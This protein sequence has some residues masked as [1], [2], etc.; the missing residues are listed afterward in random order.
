MS[1]PTL[2]GTEFQPNTT[3]LLEQD[4]PS[5]TALPNGNF[6]VVWEDRSA[7]VGDTSGD[8]VRGQLYHSNGSRIGGEFLVNQ[9]TTGNQDDAVVTAL[10]D[11]RFVVAWRNEVG[12]GNTDVYARIYNANGTPASAEFLVNTVTANAQSEPAIAAA[13]DGGFLITWTNDFSATDQDIRGRAFNAAGAP[14]GIDFPIDV[15]AGIDETD[16]AV[17]AL[18][19]NNYVVVWKDEGAPME[20]DGSGSHIR[21]KIVSD[22]GATVVPSFIINSTATGDQ[23]EPSIALLGNGG[24]V[25]TWTSGTGDS[26]EIRAR[27][28][29]SAGVP[30]GA[31]F[32]VDASSS[33]Q[34]ASVSALGAGPFDEGGFMVTWQESSDIH[35]KIFHGDGTAGESFV[36]NATLSGMQGQPRL[37]TLADGRIVATWTDLDGNSA[38]VRGQIF[39]P[40][41][42][43]AFVDG[44]DLDDHLIGTPVRDVMKGGGG[45]DVLVGLD[46]DDVFIGDAGTDDL[47]GGNGI[48]TVLYNDSNAAVSV[49]L[50]TGLGFG[51]DAQ[52]DVLSS[53]ENL[54]GSDHADS[55]HGDASNNVIKG[56]GGA[57]V[58]TGGGGIDT[59]SY[60][61]SDV[62]V[63]VS[64]ATG[65]GLGGEAQGDTLAGFRN[66]TGSN[67]GDTLIGD[68]LANVLDG[69][70]GNDTLIGGVGADTLNG[71]SGNDTLDYTA[72]DAAVLINLGNGMAGGGHATGDTFTDI[73][74]VIGTAFN[75]TLFGN[76]EANVLEGGVGADTLDGASGVDTL[77]YATSNAA[78]LINLGNGQTL[79]G[80]AQGDS[81]ASIENLI[82]SAHDDGLFG[83]GLVNVLTGG[84]GND[85]LYGGLNNDT[86]EG[87]L[88]ADTCEGGAGI[89]TLS[90]AGSN[91]AVLINVGNGMALGG[92][93]QGDSYTSIENVIGSSH[94]DGLF[95]N[96][97]ANVLT[98][99]AG[100]DYLYGGLNADIFVF[101]P[102]FGKDTIGDFKKSEGDRIQ[103]DN[104]MFQNF[105]AVQS[106]MQQV[107]A[108]TVI[109][110]DAQNAITLE[111][112]TAASL[113]ASDFLFV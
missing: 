25:V 16:A 73:Q 81:F 71:G 2:F 38:G 79:G 108:H 82:G 64:L 98:G 83:D 100:N 93:A 63:T 59:A 44:S 4:T 106:K 103:L 57:D 10:S 42:D 68:A 85:Y 97:L 76:G 17:V 26:R 7:S 51:G 70:G 9:T 107:G 5:I 13:P 30:Q 109:T 15:T 72:S 22:T 84:A 77:S 99:G 88:G 60:E 34:T 62:G 48:D 40:R 29:D 14:V 66:L 53:I 75:D 95:G 46:G 47:R 110:L 3:D 94:N 32:V 56:G 37:A 52:G 45:N 89:D 1:I 20:T 31:D 105:A 90:Y 87:G 33:A 35:G 23:S 101:G 41:T 80:H 27:L 67:S 19:N 49:N 74:N 6:V 86:L 78:V 36:V 18:N 91:A 92:H 102:G 112:V 50:S 12:A 61:G 21:A 65:T 113:Q 24:F 111:N 28:F 69:Q 96:G 39:D 43:G 54:M 104:D 11:G 55:L 58:L 8:A